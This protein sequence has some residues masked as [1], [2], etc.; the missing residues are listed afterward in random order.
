MVLAADW[1]TDP[2]RY[3]ERSFLPHSK[4]SCSTEVQRPIQQPQDS[5][6]PPPEGKPNTSCLRITQG[7]S[8]FCGPITATERCSVGAGN[9]VDGI[10]SGTVQQDGSTYEKDIRGEGDAKIK[11]GNFVNGQNVDR[12]G[13]G[14]KVQ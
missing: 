12:N 6:Q 2:G 8:K 3:P 9:F 13:Q 10:S 11:A 7:A 4:N 1:A 14:E 5:T